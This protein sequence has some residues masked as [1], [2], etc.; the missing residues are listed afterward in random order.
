MVAKRATLKSLA[1]ELGVSRQ[2]ISNAINN[3]DVVAP[4]TLERVL[5]E[6]QAQNYTPSKAAQQLRLSSSSTIALRLMPTFD[7]I[8]GH[9]LDLF[10]HELAERASEKGYRL[11]VFAAKDAKEELT[12]YSE[13]FASREIDG[14]IL[15]STT[16]DDPRFAWLTENQVPFAAFGRPWAYGPAQDPAAAP[17]PWVDVDGSAGT[18]AVVERLAAEGH[19]RIAY[20]S[21]PIEPGVGEDRYQGYARAIGAAGLSSDGLI[22]ECEDH[23]LDA[24]AAASDL[25]AAGATAIVCASDTLALGALIAVNEAE[26]LAA[27]TP[28]AT[29]AEAGTPAVVVGFDDT[30]VSRA[31][32]LSSVTQPVVEAAQVALTLLLER[33]SDSTANRQVLLAPQ[34]AFRDP[35]TE[36]ADSER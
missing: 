28:A 13:L 22:R 16:E 17:F 14:V 2:T 15:T 18:A 32:H 5:A 1:R 10:V 7:G 27:L 25:L 9:I 36:R 20:I 34:P 19:T 11:L 30:P 6:I 12:Q 26:T 8:N 4:E 35:L 23:A 3:P 29:G 33:I 31:L 24:Q 21:W